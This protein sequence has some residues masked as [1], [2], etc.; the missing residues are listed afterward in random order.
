MQRPATPILTIS[1]L[2]VSYNGHTALEQVDFS[3][4]AGEHVAIVGPNGS[5]KSTLFK[6]V[7]GLLRPNRAMWRPTTRRLVMSRSA[8][9]WTGTSQ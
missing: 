3:V 7:V 8:P 4:R 6:A 2:T 9:P 5:G 1:K